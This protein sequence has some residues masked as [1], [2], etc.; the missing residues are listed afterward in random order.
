MMETFR[1][2]YIMEKEF[3]HGLMVQNTK[4]NLKI[5]RKKEKEK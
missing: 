1:I 5:I 3:K 2:I 4:V